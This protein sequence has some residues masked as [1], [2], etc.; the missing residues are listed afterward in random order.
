M[1][2]CVKG[3]HP[4]PVLFIKGVYRGRRGA[5]LKMP[6]CTPEDVRALVHTGLSDSELEAVIESCGAELERRVG[7][8]VD[9]PLARRLCS[10]MAAQT[11]AHRLP[12]E[13][14]AGG[15]KYEAGRGFE[16]EIEALTRLLRRPRVEA[17]KYRVKEEE[18]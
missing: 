4:F 1:A 11:V 2:G 8:Q 10:L 13:F 6:Y 17:S 14:G 15:F 12:Q 5:G 16:E 18:S 9:E 7:A 3:W